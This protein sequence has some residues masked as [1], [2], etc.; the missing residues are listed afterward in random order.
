MNVS[1]VLHL[2]GQD[3]EGLQGAVLLFLRFTI[4]NVEIVTQRGSLVHPALRSGRGLVQDS[5]ALTLPMLFQRHAGP[6]APLG[7]DATAGH[8]HS[9]GSLE[10]HRAW[11]HAHYLLRVS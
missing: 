7:Q 9:F 2:A 8:Q 1:P 5:K 6:C 11:A 3:C 10:P 4:L